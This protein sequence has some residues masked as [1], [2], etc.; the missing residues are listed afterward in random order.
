MAKTIGLGAAT[1]KG[2][3]E[4]ALKKELAALKKKNAALEARVAEQAAQLAGA[5]DKA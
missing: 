2:G 3:L 1:K 4:A 5:K